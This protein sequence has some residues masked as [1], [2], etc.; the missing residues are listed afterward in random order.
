[1][2]V[3]FTNVI[4]LQ[5]ASEIHSQKCRFLSGRTLQLFQF[6]EK[7]IRNAKGNYSTGIWPELQQSQVAA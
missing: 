5:Y 4:F 2:L 6:L 7:E 1:M 3:F